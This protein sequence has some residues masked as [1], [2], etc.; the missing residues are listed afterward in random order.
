MSS[1]ENKT[2]SEEMRTWRRASGMTMVEASK[3]F[4]VSIRTYEYWESK[5]IPS[6]RIDDI[7]RFI[8]SIRQWTGRQRLPD[9]PPTWPD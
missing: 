3:R 7:R 2:L 6:N 4:G 5:E 8:E 9:R 1:N